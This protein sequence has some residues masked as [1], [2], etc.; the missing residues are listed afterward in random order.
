MVRRLSELRRETSSLAEACARPELTDTF[1][2]PAAGPDGGALRAAEG[3]PSARRDRVSELEALAEDVARAEDLAL[4]T[5][6]GGGMADPRTLASTY[7][8]LGRR[9]ADLSKGADAP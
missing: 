1:V 8:T 6:H 7:E 2:L 4:L 5:V 3:P 9:L